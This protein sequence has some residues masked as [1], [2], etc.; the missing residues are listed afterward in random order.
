MDETALLAA[1]RDAVSEARNQLARL[2]PDD[3]ACVWWREKQEFWAAVIA[4]ATAPTQS[5]RLAALGR[6]PSNSPFAM[7]KS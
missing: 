5:D 3:P 4:K 2:E 1:L 6:H 7:Q